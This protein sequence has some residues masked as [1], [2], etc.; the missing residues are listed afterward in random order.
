VLEV[1]A[2]IGRTADTVETEE[3]GWPVLAMA[4]PAPA[5]VRART[6][7]PVTAM[8]IFLFMMQ[9]LRDPSEVDWLGRL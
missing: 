6:S 1:E 2:L 9:L 4:A 7:A 5:P 8:V 3:A